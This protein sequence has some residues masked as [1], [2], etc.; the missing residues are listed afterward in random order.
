QTDRRGR[1]GGAHPPPVPSRAPSARRP[2]P[3]LMAPGA[4]QSLPPADSTCVGIPLASREDEMLSRTRSSNSLLGDG[5]AFVR[6]TSHTERS[7]G[8]T[9]ATSVPSTLTATSPD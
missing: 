4:D 1:L 7:Y 2:L 9:H 8:S 3:R 6:L 5:L